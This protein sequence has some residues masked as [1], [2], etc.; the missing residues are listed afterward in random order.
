MYIAYTELAH[1]IRE[2]ISLRPLWTY[3]IRSFFSFLF[4][5]TGFL[6]N[7]EVD[8]AGLKLKKSCLSLPSKC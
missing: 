8:Q 2:I 7:P 3:S 5:E 4:L 1:V 6:Y